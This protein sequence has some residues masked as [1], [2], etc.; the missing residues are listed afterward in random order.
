MRNRTTINLGFIGCGTVTERG[1]LPGLRSLPSARV[2]ALSDVDEDRLRRVGD[3][4][5]IP[6]RHRESRA[7]VEDPTVD[8]VAVCV[9]ARSHV[10]V[11]AAVLDAG[12]HLFVEKPL[13][14]DVEGCD[15]LIERAARSS[16]KAMVGFNLRWHR[17]IQEAR[18]FLREGSLGPPEFVRSVLTS[19]TD[20]DEA[21][22]W[23]RRRATGGGEFLETAVHHFDLWCHLLRTDV[24]EVFGRSRSSHGDDETVS[25]SARLKN[26][27]LATSAFSTRTG[28]RHEV[29]I[30]GRAGHLSASLL[31]FGDLR[32]TATTES[33]GAVRGGLRRLR[34]LIGGLPRRAARARQ[35]G[36]YVL[37]YREEWRHF[38]ECIQRDVPPS[39][40]L[41]D[42]RRALQVALAAIESAS[43]G[44]PVEVREAVR[45]VL[46]SPRDDG[47][48]AES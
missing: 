33:P 13:A 29:E 27:A 3:R 34:R 38:I 22:E 43:R 12:K 21:P 8:V 32:F 2:V 40:T 41:E 10:Q 25:V 26:G 24:E 36:D 23:R 44:V 6:R 15:A 1:H 16:C 11:A 45:A 5:G 37:S 18:A 30:Y 48:S 14:L 28:E 47:A 42:G 46:P 20:H 4:Y 7:L 39:C 17:S 31:G 9:P 35:G 19:G